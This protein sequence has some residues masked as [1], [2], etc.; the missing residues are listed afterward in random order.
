VVLPD[1]T[2]MKDSTTTMLWEQALDFGGQSHRIVVKRYNRRPDLELVKSF[3]RPS[4]AL[5]NWRMANALRLRG[6]PAVEVLAAFERRE[7]GCVVESWLV[8]RKVEGA[9]NL[10]DYAEREFAE[11]TPAQCAL[12]RRMTRELAKMISLLHERRFTQ[13][14]LKP[15][16]VLVRVEGEGEPRIEFTLIDFDGM[17]R[18]R[19]VTDARQA[20]DLS[21]LAAQFVGS[22]AVRLVDRMRFLDE[23][24]RRSGLPRETRREF[25]ARID[26][27]VRKKLEAWKSKK[28]SS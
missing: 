21:R 9:E 22:R 1:A 24:F 2:V 8:M 16:N 25:I 3:L 5:R 18:R 4:R 14:D 10:Y 12:R 15:A 23:Y 13:R 20:R 7:L 26:R 17:K 28:S 19:R 27:L 6:L 11:P